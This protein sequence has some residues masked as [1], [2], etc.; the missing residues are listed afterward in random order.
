MSDTVNAEAVRTGTTNVAVSNAATFTNTTT[1]IQR[2]N[3]LIEFVDILG[4]T[5]KTRQKA[6]LKL[7]ERIEKEQ[8]AS[9]VN[10]TKPVAVNS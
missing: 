6:V 2:S 1:F 8:S 9:D 4:N 7:V 5:V 10:L 3:G